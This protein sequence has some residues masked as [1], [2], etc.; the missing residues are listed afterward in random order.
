ML[1]SELFL[2]EGVYSL[3]N[4][5]WSRFSLYMVVNAYKGQNVVNQSL[6]YTGLHV[7]FYIQIVSSKPCLI[8][9]TWLIGIRY[10]EF[11]KFC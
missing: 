10:N 6:K 9:E 4:Y 1:S 5:N 2:T 7:L 3:Y 11:P 8:S